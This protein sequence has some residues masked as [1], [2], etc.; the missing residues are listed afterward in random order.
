MAIVVARECYTSALTARVVRAYPFFSH[1]G[2]FVTFC[3]HDDG[4][5]WVVTLTLFF[6]VS[7]RYVRRKSTFY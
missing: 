4:L 7:R 1:D 6:P 3:R 5:G 2:T